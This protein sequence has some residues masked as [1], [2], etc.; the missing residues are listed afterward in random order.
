M[1]SDAP[2]RNQ[3]LNIVKIVKASRISEMKDKELCDP[4]NIGCA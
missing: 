1:N 4:T 2:E 3:F